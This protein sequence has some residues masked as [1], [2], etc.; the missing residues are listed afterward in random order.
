M[1]VVGGAAAGAVAVAAQ[2][3]RQGGT[4]AIG[5]QER[6]ADAHAVLAAALAALHA[7]V[8]PPGAVPGMQPP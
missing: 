7:A 8:R 4:G 1:Q 3:E 5:E 2:H 6:G